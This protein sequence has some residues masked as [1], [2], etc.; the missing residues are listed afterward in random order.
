MILPV[1][2]ENILQ[3]TA[4]MI[5]MGMIGRIDVMAIAALGLSNRI[6]QLVWALFKGIGT[7]ASVFVA[8]AYGAKNYSKL[9]KVI[10]Q[11]IVSSIIGVIFFQLLVYILAPYLLKIFNPSEALLNTSL[12]HLRIVTLGLPFQIIMI[13]VAAVLQGMGNGKTPM[14]ISLIMNAVNIVVS[15]ILIF[16]I[17]GNPLGVKGAAIGLVIAQFVGAACGIYVLFN[18]DGILHSFRNKDL[19]KLDFKEIMAVCKVGLP[20]SMEAIFWQVAAIILTTIMLSFGQEA[21]ASYQVGLQAE[22]ISYMP[23]MGFAIASTAFVGQSLGAKRPDLAKAYLREALKGSIAITMISVILFLVFP[24][25]VMGLLTNQTQVINLGA[26]YLILMGLVQIPQNI[27][28]LLNGALRGA[29]YTKVPMIVAFIGLW[30]I[31]VPFSALL[32][33]V[34][35]MNIIAIWAVICAD[36]ICRFIISYTIYKKKNIYENANILLDQGTDSSNS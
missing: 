3:M 4:A 23:A 6:S 22:A 29:G 31:R 30:G 16:G 27:S 28:G 5:S 24:K 26:I 18:K 19:F 7:G 17:S 34:F 35:K 14:I 25:Q 32:T 9:K 8:Q 36:L 11:T 2:F 15:Y 1:T 21:L 20:S 13:I 33:Y 12:M 10:Q